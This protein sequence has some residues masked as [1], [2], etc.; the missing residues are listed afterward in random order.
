MLR[1]AALTCVLF[2]AAPGAYAQLDFEPCF[3]NG[4]AGNGS[5]H[6]ECAEWQRPLDPDNPD[7]ETIALFVA[8]LPSTAIDPA[9]DAFTV[10]NGG[11]GGSSIDMMVDMGGILRPFT[12]ERD[13]IVVDQRGTG[14]SS[15]L[16]CETM[17]DTT[18]DADL[19]RVIELTEECLQ[20][21]PHDPRFFTTSVA[22]KDLE[23]LRAAMGYESLSVYGVSYGS[24]VAQH[25]APDGHSF[26][27]ALRHGRSP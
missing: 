5:L 2:C 27:M 4:S 14:R 21:L 1:T 3:L 19:E 22:V 20:N 10:I 11:P 6:A 9:P 26:V 8:K 15:P 17:T 13:V 23:A 12:R 18:E 16:S 24:R 25:F 7:G